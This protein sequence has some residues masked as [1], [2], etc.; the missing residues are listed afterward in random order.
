MDSLGTTR[1]M[2]AMVQRAKQLSSL[3]Y[4]GQVGS[5]TAHTPL[6]FGSSTDNRLTPI[7]YLLLPMIQTHSLEHA[8][9]GKP[10]VDIRRCKGNVLEAV[11]YSAPTNSAITS[12]L[13]L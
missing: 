3:D 9:V 5:Q 1:T 7:S 12:E 13:R 8:T 10:T 4:S 2:L 11:P 6:R